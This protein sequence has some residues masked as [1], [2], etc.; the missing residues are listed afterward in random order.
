MVFLP[1]S[2]AL[3]LGAHKTATTHLQTVMERNASVLAA[4]G[5]AFAGPR[6]LRGSGK[7]LFDRFPG[8]RNP[9]PH[10]SARPVG[11]ELAALANGAG[12]LVL[13]EENYLGPTFPTGSQA[14]VPL[15][16]QAETRV[17]RLVELFAPL[18][19]ELFLAIRNPASFLISVFGQNLMGGKIGSFESF[20]GKI[21]PIDLSWLEL[22]TRLSNVAGL[23]GLIVWRFEDYPA[24]QSTIYRRLLG[25]SSLPDMG[26]HHRRT[27]E[28]LSETAVNETLRRAAA[29]EKGPVATVARRAFPV[30]DRN[31]A[32]APYSTS[33]LVASARIYD[34]EVSEIAGLP[35]I[36]LLCP[37]QD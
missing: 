24:L 23:A 22:L 28:G 10:A 6:D 4:A 2:I 34:L 29:G 26:Q 25:L 14:G 27:H 37:T 17:A 12:R 19:V 33:D 21:E 36:E 11:E 20:V 7:T 31:P 16:S 9:T 35:K 3:H 1:G 15:Y 13:S 18:P 8:P 30:G 32:H 5:V